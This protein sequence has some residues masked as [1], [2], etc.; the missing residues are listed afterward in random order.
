MIKM[1][2]MAIKIDNKIY[3]SIYFSLQKANGSVI[4]FCMI[5]YSLVA[6]CVPHYCR[7]ED[8]RSVLMCE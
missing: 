4:V 1:K 2:Y 6:T 5:R 8:N 3:H 7:Y